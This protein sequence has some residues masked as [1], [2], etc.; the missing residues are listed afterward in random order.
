[1]YLYCYWKGFLYKVKQITVYGNFILKFIPLNRKII[2]Y[3]IKQI[4]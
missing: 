4:I 1:M 3:T 2:V